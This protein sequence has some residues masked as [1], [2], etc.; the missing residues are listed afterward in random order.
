[1][2]IEI[3]RKALAYV[4][5]INQR[6]PTIPT[7][8]NSDVGRRLALASKTNTEFNLLILGRFILLYVGIVN[9]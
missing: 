7:T 5:L 2:V 4:F 3:R 6:R 8:E 1:L 9:K